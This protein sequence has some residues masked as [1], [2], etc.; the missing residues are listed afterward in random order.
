MISVPFWAPRTRTSARHVHQRA[1]NVRSVTLLPAP[2]AVPASPASRAAGGST[3]Y[4]CARCA[5]LPRAP[6]P[7]VQGRLHMAFAASVRPS[8]PLTLAH[9]PRVLTPRITFRCP[10]LRVR[11]GGEDDSADGSAGSSSAPAFE[12][13]GV[14][15]RRVHLSGTA[16]ASTLGEE[17]DER[18][19]A[20]ALDASAAVSAAVARTPKSVVSV[21]AAVGAEHG[22]SPRTARHAYMHTHRDA[23]DPLSFV[24]LSAPPALATAQSA[25]A[26]ALEALLAAAA[27]K[28]AAA[29]VLEASQL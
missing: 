15:R 17:D 14:R 13:E 19:I 7:R 5:C 8:P 25:F 9:L 3:L 21:S 18:R 27:L 23:P 20:R 2:H 10:V 11:G 1:A 29:S 4:A 12:D 16:A 28:A 22:S 24:G 26:D 6:T